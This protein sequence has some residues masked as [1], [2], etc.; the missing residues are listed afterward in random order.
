MDARIQKFGTSGCSCGYLKCRLHTALEFGSD[1]KNIIK[2]LLKQH[3]NFRPYVRVS[4]PMYEP[5][6][7]LSCIRIKLGSP[8]EIFGMP[9][10]F[11]KELPRGY[12]F[13]CWPGMN[14][15]IVWACSNSAFTPVIYK[16]MGID[17]MYVYIYI[18]AQA[19]V[20]V[21]YSYVCIQVNNPLSEIPKTKKLT[22]AK[23][24]AMCL[25]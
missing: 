7:W 17:D 23:W 21:L 14:F 3:E 25:A 6:L 11:L 18:Y 15:G 16:C 12:L 8:Q 24:P 4:Y 2:S 10:E 5:R 9:K 20:Y 13:V 1:C 19:H 22:K